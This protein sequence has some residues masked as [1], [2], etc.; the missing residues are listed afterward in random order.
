MGE[1]RGLSL[2][3]VSRMLTHERMRGIIE[4]PYE[5]EIFK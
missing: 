1:S 4:I 5:D 2:R 3:R